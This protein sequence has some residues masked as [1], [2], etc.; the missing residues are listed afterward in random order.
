MTCQNCKYEFCWVCNCGYT[1]GHYNNSSCRQF[2]DRCVVCLGFG[3]PN[4]HHTVGRQVS[5]ISLCLLCVPLS[6]LL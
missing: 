4:V 1:P 5:S 2:D 6:Q 3:H